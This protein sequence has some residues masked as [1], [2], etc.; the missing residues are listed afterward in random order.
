MTVDAVV[1]QIKAGPAGPRV[2]AFFDF[3]GTLIQGY[4][5]GTLLAHRAR[6]FEVGPEEIVR[7]VAAAAG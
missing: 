1:E 7:I 2:A 4:S 3:D 6:K 5:A